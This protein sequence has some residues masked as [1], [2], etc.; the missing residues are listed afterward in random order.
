MAAP[1]PSFGV[2]WAW[3]DQFT[4]RILHHHA[5]FRKESYVHA[6]EHHGLSHGHELI[7]DAW[8][9]LQLL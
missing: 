1:C 3:H 7:F 8:L 9:K 6:F 4:K 2:T 5:S